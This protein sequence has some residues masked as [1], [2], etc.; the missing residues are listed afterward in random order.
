MRACLL[1]GLLGMADVGR[2]QDIDASVAP[3]SG[4]SA[5]FVDIKNT[6]GGNW[7]FWTAPTPAAASMSRVESSE[8]GEYP[9]P[10]PGSFA[11]DPVN[12]SQNRIFPNEFLRVYPNT[13]AVSNVIQVEFS[14]SP[15]G[16]HYHFNVTVT[17]GAQVTSL[18]IIDPSP[19]AASIVH[20]RVSFDRGISGLTA[21]NFAFANVAGLTNVSITGISAD[22]AQPS[23]NWTITVNSGTGNGLLGLNW[24]G[25]SSES[26]SVPNSFV[27]QVYD[28]SSYPIIT[29]DPVG[30]GINRNTTWTMI[31]AA[32]VRGASVNYQWY[33]G[34]S[35]NPSAATA[36]P[37]ATNSSYTPLPFANLGSYQYFCHAYTTPGYYGNSLT[38]TITV[39]DPPNI[40][41]Q[42]ANTPVAITHPATFTVSATGTSLQYQ[43]FQGTPPDM[44][45][46][47]GSNYPVLVTA[48]LTANTT[49]WVQITNVGPTIANSVAATAVVIA[50]LTPAP[51]NY[52]NIVGAA[53]PSAF[54]VTARDYAN[55]LASIVPVT[56]TAPSGAV[57]S[58]AFPGPSLSTTNTT[59]G[60]GVAVAPTCTANGVCGIYNVNANFSIL[61]T[62]F[63]CTNLPTF[64][65]ATLAGL[66]N[67]EITAAYNL[68][69]ATGAQSPGGTFS[70]AGVSGGNFNPAGAGRGPHVITYAVNG[71]QASFTIAVV[72]TPSLVVTTNA[73]VVNPFDGVTSLREA[74]A[75]ATTLSG[76][77]TITFAPALSGQT[78]L[79]TNGQLA[80]NHNLTIDGSS[81]TNSIRL[82][83]NH[84]SR[85][86][87][88]AGGVNATLNALVL[89]NGHT[90]NGNWGGAIFNAGT[91]GLNYC[92]LAG[93]SGDSSVYGGAI[94]NQGP[95]TVLGCTF[96]GNS[97]GFS[98]AIDN[99]STCTLQNSTFYGN[100][101]FAGN[102]GA[103]DNSFSATLSVLQ[104]TFSGNSAS[105]LG[106]AI[107]N[108][109]SQV[110][111]TNSI[112][113]GNSGQDI[114][115][116]NGSTIDAGGA[117][118]IP[119][120]GN[121]GTLVGGGTISSANPLLGPLANNGGP[122]LTMMPQPGSPAIDAGVSILAAGLLYDQRGPV[123][124]RVV[125]KAVDIGAV[126]YWAPVIN[127]PSSVTFFAGLSNSFRLAAT[128]G[129]TPT[130]AVAGSFPPGV[131]FTLPATLS[132]TPP[133]GS[134][135]IYSLTVI[136]SNSVPPMATQYLTLTVV[137]LAARPSF[138]TNGLGWVLNGDMV[139]GGPKITNNVFTLTDGTSGE[140]RSGW[141]AFPLYVGAFQASYTYQDFGGGGADGTAFVVQNDPRGPAA[142]GA[143]GGGLG[144]TGITPSAAVLLNLYAGA[145]GGASGMLVATNGVGDGAGYS[146]S[147][148]Q[149]TAP[150]NLDGG[151]PINVNLRYTDGVLRINLADTVSGATF[152]ASYPINIPS[153]VG[154]NVAWV[155][156]TGSE[157]G[158][159]SHQTVSNFNY[160]PLPVLLSN[161][162][163]GNSVALS[164][165]A[166]IYG[167]HLQS[168]SNLLGN[169][170]ADLP[171][172]V[173]QANGFNLATV[174]TS[175]TSQFF[176][177]VL[178]P[179]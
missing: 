76:P 59:T 86:F 20:W 41:T 55:N 124:P 128:G 13:V 85:L 35:Q 155:G 151:N 178:P 94:A 62:T 21:A 63:S 98:G 134:G 90:T 179:Q 17:P 84:A 54:T 106:G 177:L 49:Y 139:N 68:A 3:N 40:V 103:I 175:G 83:G 61:S 19:S 129:S 160:V 166:S 26:P 152:Q 114:Y 171:A 169:V 74:L 167:Y 38:A 123:Y 133:L 67:T 107:D 48:P 34:S 1:A 23:T 73:D 39:V 111:V 65:A 11:P 144:Y 47:V 9:W 78:I 119:A 79:V 75:Y 91:L 44:S 157:G 130:I 66:T 53:Y 37:G 92:T 14:Y 150:V 149:N 154:T 146:T 70:G 138:N 69:T 15:S 2:A 5:N 51:G 170:W 125:G 28:F 162:G 165:P 104:C 112:L 116:W 102:G 27:G 136:A 148:Y 101:A 95:L 72:E 121:A 30:R 77:Q 16:T 105:G 10:T 4:G 122:T 117:N 57:P 127:S 82:D 132:G 96:S 153:F 56:F 31:A 80:L 164:W 172:I 6:S 115:N 156:I 46:P 99:R 58:G 141:F 32:V 174:A 81:L 137:E 97:A 118:I 143:P 158:I 168:T 87:S 163:S 109:L 36:I 126:E 100:V 60:S 25:H 159:L 135:G 108:Y 43:W 50:S 8:I 145:A 89:T 22:A 71:V 140:N 120:V 173:T 113:S 147:V 131:S 110:N 142:L 29:L 7:Y 93:N 24:A 161:P 12:I 45:T 18:N 176:R 64:N 88:V 33:S 52:R 42:P